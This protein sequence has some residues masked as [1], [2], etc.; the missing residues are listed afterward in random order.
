MKRENANEIG[1]VINFACSC[2]GFG[3]KWKNPNPTG[4]DVSFGLSSEQPLYF[5]FVFG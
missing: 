5:E 1:Q 2:C 3:F 4:V